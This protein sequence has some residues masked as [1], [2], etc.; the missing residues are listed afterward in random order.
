MSF[1]QIRRDGLCSQRTWCPRGVWPGLTPGCLLFPAM[2]IA[3][4]LVLTAQGRVHLPG[5]RPRVPSLGSPTHPQPCCLVFVPRSGCEG[6]PAVA[7]FL[8]R[9]LPICDS[10]EAWPSFPR[11]LTPPCSRPS[12]QKIL[13]PLGGPLPPRLSPA[14]GCHPAT[15]PGSLPP[16]GRKRVSHAVVAPCPFPRQANNTPQPKPRL[17]RLQDVS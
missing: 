5:L 8:C 10:W 1:C 7:T 4:T 11:S 2:A 6:G 3:S 9:L 13:D 12:V 15:A 14:H 17:C 16:A